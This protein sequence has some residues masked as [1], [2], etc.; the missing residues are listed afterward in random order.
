MADFR[1]LAL[2]A[3]LLDGKVAEA[4]VKLLKKELYA[5]GKI[6]KKEV[7][8]LIELRNSAKKQTKTGRINPVFE[9]FFFKALAANVLDNGIISK[10]EASFL[11]SAIF[12][13]G[14]VDASEKKF[15]ARLRRTATKVAPEF[16]RL[17]EE[18]MSK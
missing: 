8:F 3:I 5:D 13:D 7:D 18:C 15:L 12:A 14:K 16:E 6:D 1:N 2:K 17:Y 9:K 10:R 4:E 11:R